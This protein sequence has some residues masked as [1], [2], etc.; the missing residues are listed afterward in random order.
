MIELELPIAHRRAAQHCAQ[1]LSRA[2]DPLD[3]AQEVA[4]LAQRFAQEAARG[5]ADL[6]DARG[7]QVEVEEP[8]LLDADAVLAAVGV[9]S[10]NSFLSLGT[11][12][13]GALLSI[14]TCE[15]NAQFERLLGGDGLVDRT[16]VRLPQ[17]AL[18][19]VS[20][21]EQQILTALRSAARREEFELA[22]SLGKA[23]DIAPYAKGDE[24]WVLDFTVVPSAGS[25]WKLT[26]ALCRAS[27]AQLVDTRAASPATGR[28]IGERGIDASAIG[29][30]ELPM[31]AILVDSAIPLSRLTQLQV[32][33]IIPIAVNRSIPLLIEHAVIAHGTA[34]EIDDNIAL[35]ITHTSLPG[36]H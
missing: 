36:L 29:Q 31:C 24:V 1:L 8:R 23:A 16:S 20:R 2:A 14:A 35:E 12:R 25:Q 15:V 9:H 22:A 32:G 33:A 4:G 18:P 13:T 19:F 17:S 3:P 11:E 34:G 28:A 21:L 27:L 6:C 5:L 26:M 7:L 30:M 10:V